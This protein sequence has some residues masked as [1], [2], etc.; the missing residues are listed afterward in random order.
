MTAAVPD[1]SALLAWLLEEPGHE[2]VE[3]ALKGAAVSA[4]N[5]S[6]VI[7]EAAERD[8]VLDDIEGDFAALEVTVMPFE[9]EDARRAALL[10]ST[11]RALGLSFSDRACLALAQRLKRPVLTAHR[12]WRG[13]KLGM[14]VQLIRHA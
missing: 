10:W 13:L 5:L 7:Q 14:L 2:S 8:I 1:A 12:S 6:E 4:V 3:R 9:T 11:T